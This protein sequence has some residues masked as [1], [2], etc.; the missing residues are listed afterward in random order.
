MKN[1]YICCKIRQDYMLIFDF[2]T[3]LIPLRVIKAFQ[4][5]LEN[6]KKASLSCPK[7]SF[8]LVS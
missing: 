4:K 5:S 3:F 1:N 6:V 8:F 2:G 7:Q